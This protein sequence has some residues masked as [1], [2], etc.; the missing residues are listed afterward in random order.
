LFSVCLWFGSIDA[1]LRTSRVYIWEVGEVWRRKKE[2]RE[3]RVAGCQTSDLPD[4]A[5][6]VGV[7]VDAS[8]FSIETT[9]VKGVVPGFGCLGMTRKG[10]LEGAWRVG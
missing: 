5:V 1:W 7:E 10:R 4:R 3:G 8:F 2:A 9:E 6:A